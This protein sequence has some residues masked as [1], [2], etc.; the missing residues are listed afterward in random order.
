M[1]QQHVILLGAVP[2]P[3]CILCRD[4]KTATIVM[5]GLHQD[6]SK[7]PTVVVLDEWPEDWQVSACVVTPIMVLGTEGITS[8]SI[9]G[10][11]EISPM[12]RKVLNAY[13]NLCKSIPPR[14]SYRAIGNAT[15]LDRRQIT[16]AIKELAQAGI[17]TVK[18]P[19]GFDANIGSWHPDANKARALGIEITEY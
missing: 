7:K 4:S 5:S 9:E 11:E 8:F 19:Q 12:A 6:W 10:K 13:I 14:V 16:I 3:P 2:E 17:G 15:G 18:Y 1:P